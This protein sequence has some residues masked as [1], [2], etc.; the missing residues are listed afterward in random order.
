MTEDTPL[1]RI[2]TEDQEQ[3]AIDD[4]ARRLS[5]FYASLT[6]RG[7][8]PTDVVLD[9]INNAQTTLWLRFLGFDD[10]EDE[11]IGIS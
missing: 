5:I 2:A 7:M 11:G 3:A 10:D 6:A 8:M 4:I 1:Y 9:L